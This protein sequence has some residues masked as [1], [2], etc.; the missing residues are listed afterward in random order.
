MSKGFVTYLTFQWLLSRVSHFMDIVVVLMVK[1]IVTD[2]ALK[3]LF[4]S[5]MT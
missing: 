5:S 3:R 1:I 2:F 4:T